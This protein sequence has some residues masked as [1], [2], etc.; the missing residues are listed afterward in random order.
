M[1]RAFR[2]RPGDFKRKIIARIISSRQNLLHEENR[3]LQMIKDDELGNK[4]YN[5]TKHMN[6]HW[7]TNDMQRIAIG[8]K[9]SSSPLR[10]DRIRNHAIG[11]TL[12]S[13]SREK[14]RQARLGT[15]QSEETKAKRNANRHHKYDDSFKQKMS[16]IARNRSVETRQKISENSRKLQAEG[17]IGM[18][19]KKHRQETKDKISISVKGKNNINYGKK[20]YTDGVSSKLIKSNEV[21]LGW[22]K[23]RTLRPQS[24]KYTQKEYINGFQYQ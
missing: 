15:K 19:N 16:T 17:R 22:Y 23:G 8:E 1:R 10:K 9:I 3:W 11:R 14:I 12:S 13:E 4:F 5:L 18:K 21:P 24:D 6:G 2:R 7:S 20:W